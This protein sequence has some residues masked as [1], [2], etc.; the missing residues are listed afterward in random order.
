[1]WIFLFKRQ[2]S[3]A[4]FAQLAFQSLGKC[5]NQVDIKM[6]SKSSPWE[7]RVIDQFAPYPLAWISVWKRMFLREMILIK[8]DWKC[9]LHLCISVILISQWSLISTNKQTEFFRCTVK[10]QTHW[11]QRDAL[12]L[13][14]YA[15]AKQPADIICCQK[16]IEKTPEQR[17]EAS[18]N[19]AVQLCQNLSFPNQIRTSWGRG[20][21][22]PNSTAA[23]E[24]VAKTWKAEHLKMAL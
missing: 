5:L 9:L 11:K 1:M 7:N 12:R 14:S 19:G 16:S 21:R 15:Q 8:G 18:L 13:H 24:K 10:A 3:S 22:T 20:N 2:D 4:N 6:S 23:A 17:E